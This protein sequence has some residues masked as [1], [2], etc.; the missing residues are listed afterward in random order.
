VPASAEVT[1]VATTR[2]VSFVARPAGVS[3]AAFIAALTIQAEKAKVLS[4][5]LRGLV[6]SD[7]APAANTGAPQLDVDALVEVWTAD[8]ADHTALLAT[9]DGKKWNTGMDALYGKDTT[10]VSHEY[11]FIRPKT[12]GGTRNVGLLVRK[13]GWN[14]TDFMDHWLGIH[15]IMATKVDGL[16]GFVVNAIQRTETSKGEPVMQENDGI[17]EVWDSLETWGSSP[18]GAGARPKSDYFK[19]WVKDGNTFIQ[20]DKSRSVTVMGNEII[21]VID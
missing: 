17:A 6:I 14:H 8:E 5:P 21:P 18:G 3:H 2:Y 16:T 10:Y 1:P 12:R 20:R 15:G 7:V 19:A 13:D 11:R 9:S 4:H